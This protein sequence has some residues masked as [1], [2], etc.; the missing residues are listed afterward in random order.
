MSISL[1]LCPFAPCPHPCPHVPGL[2]FTSQSPCPYLSPSPLSWYPSLSLCPYPRACPGASRPHTHIP[3]TS[4]CL[5]ASCPFLSPH[6]RPTV[7]QQNPHPITR[8][9]PV[10]R[11]APP[12]PRA[13]ARVRALHGGSSRAAG[14]SGGA[15]GRSQSERVPPDSL[16]PPANQRAVPMA[17]SFPPPSSSDP[18]RL[19]R[20]QGRASFP[21]RT[22]LEAPP[23]RP[24]G[25]ESPPR[26]RAAFS[27][28]LARAVAA[29]RRGALR[30]RRLCS[31]AMAA[32]CGRP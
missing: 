6:P 20:P 12:A 18:G 30:R 4:P 32:A 23:F 15:P 26:A 22:P 7:P 10:F 2:V 25:T 19:P 5:L 13:H 1:S 28:H 17:T 29:A 21:G 11:R 8:P 16:R 9:S 14:G 3:G 31:S 24:G 27:P